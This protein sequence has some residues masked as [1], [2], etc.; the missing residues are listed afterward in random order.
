MVEQPDKP[1]VQE[2]SK[3]SSIK[4]EEEIPAVVPAIQNIDEEKVITRLSFNDMDS[5]LDMGSNSVSKIEAPKSLE[6]LEEIST[7]RAFQ[8][9]LDEE[10][11]DEDRIQIHGEQ[12]DLSGFDI[13]DEPSNPSQSRTGQEVLL[14]DFE[15]LY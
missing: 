11:D 3:E 14:N 8:R 15:E 6:R 2:S 7:A 1:L 13:L 9:K 12:I 5:V 4:D 10:E